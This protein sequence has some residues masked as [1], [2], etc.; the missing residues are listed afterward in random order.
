MLDAKSI[1]DDKLGRAN[2]H[3][4]KLV[5][6]GNYPKGMYGGLTFS[7]VET[8]MEVVRS[9]VRAIERKRYQPPQSPSGTKPYVDRQRMAAL[10]AISGKQWDFTRLLELCREINVAAANGCHITTAMLLRTIL[11]HVPPVLGFKTFAQVANNYGDAEAKSFK[12]S[13]QRLEGS[14]RNIADMHLHTRI[15]QREDLPTFVQV[16]FAAELDILL[17][18]VI[19]VAT[20]EQSKTMFKP[21]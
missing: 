12:A 5:S 9:G 8:A 2:D 11:N 18:E 1:L 4:I 7:T 21:R 17:G 13:M 10:Q 3:S 19:R 15:R 6:T 20:G 16:D 14:L